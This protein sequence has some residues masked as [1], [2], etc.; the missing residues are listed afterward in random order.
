MQFTIVV[1]IKKRPKLSLPRLLRCSRLNR[2]DIFWASEQEAEVVRRGRY[3]ME[4]G[5]VTTYIDV[6]KEGV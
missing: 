6:H 2:N 4:M 3:K 1:L 5:L